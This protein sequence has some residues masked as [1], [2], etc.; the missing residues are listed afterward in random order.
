MLKHRNSSNKRLPYCCT[1]TN[2]TASR[3]QILC[4]ETG[5]TT[6][7]L[8]HLSIKIQPSTL[9][10]A[11]PTQQSTFVGDPVRPTST[12]S[13]LSPAPTSSVPS[14]TS[15]ISLIQC[16]S[17]EPSE[18]PAPIGTPDPSK[19]KQKLTPKTKGG[20]IVGAIA[21]A[22]AIAFVLLMLCKWLQRRRHNRINSVNS[23]LLPG[24]RK[25][26]R[27][28]TRPSDGGGNTTGYPDDSANSNAGVEHPTNSRKKLP[29]K[30]GSS[31]GKGHLRSTA[32]EADGNAHDWRFWQRG[33]AHNVTPPTPAIPVNSSSEDYPYS[34]SS[35]SQPTLISGNIELLALPSSNR[36]SAVMN[37]PFAS[38]TAEKFPI[39][40]VKDH[41]PSPPFTATPTPVSPIFSDLGSVATG[42]ERS[43]TGVSNIDAQGANTLRIPDEEIENR[44]KSSKL[45]AMAGPYMTA[46]MALGEG[47]WEAEREQ[48]EAD[49]A[50]HEVQKKRSPDMCDGNIRKRE[51][52]KAMREKSLDEDRGESWYKGV[53]RASSG[54]NLRI[55]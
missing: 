14:E 12:E 26:S 29:D 45:Y 34:P 10:G 4:S 13:S 2:P 36:G 6:T 23:G 9:I 42:N 50:L 18:T 8:P 22:A 27:D 21:G 43:G 47:Y 55:G 32:N 39:T 30:L 7:I 37:D 28:D 25:E 31:D 3:Y 52:D 40:P 51:S 33:R 38:P 48:L 24:P 49:K 53:D 5:G 17:T 54:Q 41:N 1:V 11:P 35:V 20:I 15:G 44:R 16:S 19:N 46:E